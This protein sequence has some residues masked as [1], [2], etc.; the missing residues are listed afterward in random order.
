M[1]FIAIT[2]HITILL[3]A[4][5]LLDRW[6]GEPRRFHPLVGF[7]HAANLVERQLNAGHGKILRG[8]LGWALLVLPLPLLLWWALAQLPP[9]LAAVISV[10]VLYFTLG[11]QSLIEHTQPIATALLAGDLPRARELTA[12]IVSRDLRQADEAAITRA[13]TESLLENGHDAVFGALFW[14]AVGGAPAAL[15]FRFA[16]TLDAMWGYRNDRFERFGKVAARADDVLGYIPSRLTALAYALAG[17]TRQALHCWR[18]QAPLWDSPNAG[19]VMAAGAGALGIKLGGAAIYH[20]KEEARPDL[21]AGALPVAADIR[22]AARLMDI[23][24]VIWLLLALPL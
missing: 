21:G 2:L 11:R 7:G 4:G 12:R 19:P 18:T 14:F 15:A 13:A 5:L 8:L 10:L 23:A 20:G 16:N 17:H 6:L 22:R 24:I 3:A 1:P 9:T